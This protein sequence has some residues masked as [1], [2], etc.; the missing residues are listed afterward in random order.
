MLLLCLSPTFLTCLRLRST[1][2]HGRDSASARPSGSLSQAQAG[3]PGAWAGSESESDSEEVRE[4]EAQSRLCRA[5]RHGVG[6]SHRHQSVTRNCPPGPEAAAAAGPGRGPA[7][8]R[9]YY[10]YGGV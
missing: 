8:R 4:P 10:Y 5:E 3:R 1:R 2:S 9:F 7:A 6:P